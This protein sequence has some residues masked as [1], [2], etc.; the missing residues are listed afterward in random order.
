VVKKKF[1]GIFFIFEKIPKNGERIAKVLETIKLNKTL[2]P[3]I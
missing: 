2:M 3:R 1:G